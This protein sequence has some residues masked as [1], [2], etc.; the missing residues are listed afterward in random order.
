MRSVTGIGTPRTLQGQ[1]DQPAAH[2]IA[3]GYLPFRRTWSGLASDNKNSGRI[4]LVAR[5]WPSGL[6]QGPVGPPAR[7]LPGNRRGT[8][9]GHRRTTR[10]GRRPASSAKPLKPQA[11]RA[12]K[13]QER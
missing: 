1:G 12:S 11:A 3:P 6:G 5:Q 13:K 2:Q 10:Q 7:K 8:R 4:L 9:V